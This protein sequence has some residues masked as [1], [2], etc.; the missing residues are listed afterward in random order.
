[1]STVLGK[2]DRRKSLDRAQ[3]RQLNT[4]CRHL[5]SFLQ[6]FSPCA[7]PQAGTQSLA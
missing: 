6:S 4:C 5:T 7:T 2:Q 1:M 3:P